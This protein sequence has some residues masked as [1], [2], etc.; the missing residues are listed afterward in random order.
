MLW[1]CDW[2][3]NVFTFV[4]FYKIN[5]LLFYT[6]YTTNELFLIVE[7]WDRFVTWVLRQICHTSFETD[8]SHKRLVSEG[9]GRQVQFYMLCRTVS[10]S[11]CRKL[12]FSSCYAVL[13]IVYMH[14][15]CFLQKPPYSPLS[16]C[17]HVW[18][19]SHCQQKSICCKCLSR[20]V[21]PS[22]RGKWS[23][24]HVFRFCFCSYSFFWWVPSFNTLKTYH[25]QRKQSWKVYVL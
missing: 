19:R 21:P 15:L 2:L 7:F 18:K 10:S 9:E 20:L 23:S 13:Y 6:L 24:L 16:H 11:K 25:F 17:S 8:L 3:C 14:I 4:F 5:E 22:F 1:I 12:L